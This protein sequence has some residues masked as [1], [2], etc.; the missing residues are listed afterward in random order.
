MT[1][2]PDSLALRDIAIQLRAQANRL[3]LAADDADR[4]HRR[5]NAEVSGQLWLGRFIEILKT[6]PSDA[7]VVFDDGAVPGRWNS[8]RGNYIDLAL[9]DTRSPYPLVEDVLRM[10]VAALTEPFLG[11]K[12]GIYHM[13]A[14]TV[15]WRASYGGWPGVSIVG[16]EFRE[17]RPGKCVILTGDRDGH[18]SDRESCDSLLR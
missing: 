16:L 17:G 15:L 4:R 14:D 8:Y 6:M 13:T 9:E 18:R 1:A 11:W 3:D 12:D 7:A 10:S 2:A 5:A